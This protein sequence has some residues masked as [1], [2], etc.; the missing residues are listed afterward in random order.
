MRDSFV[1]YRGFFESFMDLPKKDRLPLFES[2]CN[3]ALNDVEPE[4]TGVASAVFKLLKPQV[5]SNNR[6]YEN[7]LKGGKPKSNQNV[8]KSKPKSNQNVTKPEP[9]DNVNVNENE[10]ENENVSGEAPDRPA[11]LSEFL[12]SYLN[13]KAGAKYNVTANVVKRIA[14]LLDAGYT[15]ED[16]VS[17]IDSK[18]CEWGD[19]EKMRTYL[20]PRT[21]FGEKFEDYVLAPVPAAIEERES[22]SAEIA[23]LTE[24]KR[25]LETDVEVLATQ[26][27]IVRN[28]VVAGFGGRDLEELKRDLEELKIEKATKEQRIEFL[29]KRMERLKE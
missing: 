27:G 11:S 28:G 26:I 13:E 19:S 9:N 16:M 17:V 25:K 3:Y 24:E 5:D 29:E 22:R 6:R 21:L 7:G 12:I 2:L 14:E 4:L 1:F 10:N 15:R 8:T 18:V 20:R 23:S